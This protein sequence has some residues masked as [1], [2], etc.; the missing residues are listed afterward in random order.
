MQLRWRV[1]WLAIVV[2]FCATAGGSSAQE[3]PSRPIKLVVGFAPGGTTD[4]MAR[5]VADKLRGPPGQPVVP[6]ASMR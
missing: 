6:P 1:G 2:A 3:F 4:F 5:L